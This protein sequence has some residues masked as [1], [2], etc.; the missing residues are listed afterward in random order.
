MCEVSLRSMQFLKNVLFESFEALESF[1]EFGRVNGV[2][3]IAVSDLHVD[4][5]DPVPWPCSDSIPHEEVYYS[6]V[7]SQAPSMMLE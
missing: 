4:D 5:V 2:G 7:W 1:R 6:M 3:I